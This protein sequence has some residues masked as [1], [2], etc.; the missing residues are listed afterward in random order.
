[1]HRLLSAR[2][3]NCAVRGEAIRLSPHFYQGEQELES[4]MSVL[5]DVLS[6]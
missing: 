2:A 6:S 5:E 1:L 3:V 4:F